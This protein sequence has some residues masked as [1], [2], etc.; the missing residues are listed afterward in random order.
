MKYFWEYIGIPALALGAVFFAVLCLVWGAL[1]IGD[2][3]FFLMEMEKLKTVRSAV[4]RLGPIASED[5][6]GKAVDWN[7]RIAMRK[8]W[9]SWWVSD[10]MY[11]DRWN[12]VEPIEISDFRGK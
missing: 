9:N 8:Y 10:W 2:R 12:L 5:V 4:E 7:E 11:D 1:A 3:Y 6:M